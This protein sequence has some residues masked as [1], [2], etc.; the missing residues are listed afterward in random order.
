MRKVLA[1]IS[2]FAFVSAG[3]K[4]QW[5]DHG[6]W[7]SAS[8]SQKVIRKTVVTVD[9]A[10]RFD[11][12]YTRLGSTFIDAEVSREVADGLNVN[13]AFRGG[14]SNTNEYQWEPQRRVAANIRYKQSLGDKSSISVRLQYQSGYKG[15]R[16]PGES[17]AFSKAARSKLTYFYKVAK[18]YRL[19]LSAETF[20][21]PL[22]DIYEWSDIRG[23]ISVRKQLAKRKYLTLGYQ[24]ET[25]RGGPD[26]WVEHAIICS[27]ALEKKRRKSD[28]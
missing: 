4:A 22:Y 9:F 14:A 7:T 28:K 27:F 6:A 3:L 15:A 26:P 1:T 20:F 8:I 12:D 11:R 13:L 18:G 5:V 21:R 24:V 25:P 19:S 16:M 10:A 17:L 23:R 2:F